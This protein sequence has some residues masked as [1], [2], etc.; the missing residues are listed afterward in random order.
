[1]DPEDVRG[2]VS[3]VDLLTSLK[4]RR[5][6]TEPLIRRKFDALSR[7]AVD[8]LPFLVER[9]VVARHGRLTPHERDGVARA[10]RGFPGDTAAEVAHVHVCGAVAS[11]EAVGL[12]RNQASHL[13]RI[14]LEHRAAS[15]RRGAP[16]R[17]IATDRHTLA[18]AELAKGGE[19]S[20]KAA[21]GCLCI[22]DATVL[23]DGCFA[24][25]AG[26]LLVG[27]A[28]CVAAT[29]QVGAGARVAVCC[30][31]CHR[32]HRAIRKLARI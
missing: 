8:A 25:A 11:E 12:A 1:M 22:S 15:R 19:G 20:E 26:A 18:M 17:P 32:A 23:D 4:Q 10:V 24:S 3:L 27:T 13:L 7:P 21:L 5:P 9:A 6:P 2:A 29:D 28:F 14:G 16:L 30:G 31:T